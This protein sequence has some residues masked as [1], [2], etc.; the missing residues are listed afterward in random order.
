MIWKGC[1]ADCRE[2]G[3]VRLGIRIDNHWTLLMG[4]NIV[5][6]KYSTSHENSK[7]FEFT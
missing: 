1:T 6:Y 7:L 5:Q 2:Q 4:F 3:P